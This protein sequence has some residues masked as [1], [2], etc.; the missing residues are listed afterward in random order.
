MFKKISFTSPYILITMATQNSLVLGFKIRTMMAGMS[1]S[2]VGEYKNKCHPDSWDRFLPAIFKGIY[3]RLMPALSGW[4]RVYRIT[5]G[6][7]M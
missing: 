4:T 5:A 3:K 1:R 2:Q 6:H 7:L